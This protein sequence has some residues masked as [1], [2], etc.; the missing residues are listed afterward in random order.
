MGGSWALS[1]V[2]DDGAEIPIKPML[3]VNAELAKYNWLRNR[4]KRKIMHVL[5]HASHRPK[6]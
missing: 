6:K 5:W 4:L 2:G 1:I 3:E